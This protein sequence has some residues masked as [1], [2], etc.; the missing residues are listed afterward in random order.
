MDEY[1]LADIK[2]AGKRRIFEKIRE[3]PGISRLEISNATSLSLMT[4][5]KACDELLEKNIVTYERSC[6]ANVGRKAKNI[7][8]NDD[9]Y[10]AVLK[11]CKDSVYFSLFTASLAPVCTQNTPLAGF[12]SEIKLFLIENGWAT[13]ILALGVIGDN[14]NFAEVCERELKIRAY[15]LEN[16]FECAARGAYLAHGEPILFCKDT[17]AAHIEH[18]HGNIRVGKLDIGAQGAVSEFLSA[19]IAKADADYADFEVRGAAFSLCDKYI[20]E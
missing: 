8:L 9:A 17:S 16:D 13:K 20:T 11:I 3:N 5:G 6:T 18:A 2:K 19:K 15:S 14:D 4:V 1:T 10:L 7:N 12:F